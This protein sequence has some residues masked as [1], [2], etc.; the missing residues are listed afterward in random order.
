MYFLIV[1][2]KKKLYYETFEVLESLNKHINDRKG[3]FHSKFKN[4]LAYIVKGETIL[5]TKLHL[6]EE[7]DA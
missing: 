3:Y 6:D 1:Y 2:E 4:N 5:T 7:N